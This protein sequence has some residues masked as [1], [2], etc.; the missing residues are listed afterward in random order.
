MSTDCVYGTGALH[1]WE[2]S[3][4]RASG[5]S[6]VSVHPARRSHPY[7]GGVTALMGLEAKL[8]LSRTLVVIDTHHD[9]IPA[10]VAALFD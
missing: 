1:V 6:P 7:D 8:R 9:D 10:F 4:A 3:S 5:E 2:A